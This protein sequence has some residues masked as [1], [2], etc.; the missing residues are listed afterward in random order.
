MENEELKQALTEIWDSLTDEQKE[1]AQACTSYEEL[2]A[3]ASEEKIELPA[4]F[5]DEVAGG[6]I[7][8]DSETVGYQVIRDSD[9]EVLARDIPTLAEAR[10]KAAELGQD[11]ELTSWWGLDGLR[12]SAKRC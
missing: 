5:L 10:Q 2:V 11:G 9:G 7:F 1:R 8:S 4:D 12:K 6:R 3:L